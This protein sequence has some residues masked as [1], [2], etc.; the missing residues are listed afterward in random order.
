MR[1]EECAQ[2]FAPGCKR[3]PVMRRSRHELKANDARNDQSDGRKPRRHRGLAEEINSERR[4]ADRADAG[5]TA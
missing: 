1:I 3:M 5:H 2:E 4:G